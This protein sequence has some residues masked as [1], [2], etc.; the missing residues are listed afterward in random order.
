MLCTMC[1]RKNLKCKSI[2]KGQVL[3]RASGLQ[4][5][6]SASH[7]TRCYGALRACNWWQVLVMALCV[8]AKVGFVVQVCL[9][10]TALKDDNQRLANKLDAMAISGLK[11]EVAGLKAEVVGLKAEV[12]GLKDEDLHLWDEAWRHAT[13]TSYAAYYEGWNHQYEC[14]HRTPKQYRYRV[15][16]LRAENKTGRIMWH[17]EALPFH[18]CHR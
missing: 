13:S 4:L 16:R 7:G 18:R 10:V 5:V 1:D 3:R 8:I 9:L 17:D 11:T 6:A 14:E 2:V 15:I 12:V